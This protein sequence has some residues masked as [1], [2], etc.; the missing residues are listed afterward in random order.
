M[1]IL[2]LEKT[3]SGYKAVDTDG[4]V[5]WET[6]TKRTYVAALGLRDVCNY[7]FGRED[8]IGKG[9][10]RFAVSAMRDEHWIA[11]GP[12]ITPTARV[13]YEIL[14]RATKED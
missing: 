9:A 10:S 5:V 2:N 13:R 8:L 7:R 12:E 6:K 14:F 4:E 1:R 11:F 3:K